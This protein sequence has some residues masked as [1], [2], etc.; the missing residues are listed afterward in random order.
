MHSLQMGCS[1][2]TARRE[3]PVQGLFPDHTLL[4]HLSRS[5]R[6]PV[7][8]LCLCLF[9]AE[10]HK[11]SPFF[12]SAAHLLVYSTPSSTSLPLVVIVIVTSTYSSS[13]AMFGPRYIVSDI[14]GEPFLDPK[15]LRAASPYLLEHLR[16]TDDPILKEPYARDLD[17]FMKKTDAEMQYEDFGAFWRFF[18]YVSLN[19][20]I[21]DRLHTI[22]AERFVRHEYLHTHPIS[23]YQFREIKELN[24]VPRMSSLL[25]HSDDRIV[26]QAIDVA[27][28]CMDRL[29]G[30]NCWHENLIDT[31]MHNRIMKLMN[32]VSPEDPFNIKFIARKLH[33]RYIDF[34]VKKRA[35]E[36]RE[37]QFQEQQE[38]QGRELRARLANGSLIYEQMV[39]SGEVI[40]DENTPGFDPAVHSANNPITRNRGLPDNEDN[41]AFGERA[42]ETTEAATT[43][44]TPAVNTT[45][46]T[47][48][49]GTSNDQEDMDIDEE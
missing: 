21:A 43:A 9:F 7:G 17:Q 25:T 47:G 22:R 38:A 34:V 46:A 35:W 8:S 4:F 3:K 18:Q 19:P 49:Q 13:I 33:E 1:T 32:R 10:S 6:V 37:R 5:S 28:Q 36:E 45:A 15:A 30:I 12:S 39:R 26:G 20:D 2:K 44:T 23:R 16:N 11:P 24:V 14:K 41:F 42:R 40:E 31:E 29:M 27:Y 48:P